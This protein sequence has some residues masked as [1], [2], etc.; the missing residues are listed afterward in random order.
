M[1]RRSFLILIR[2]N[3]SAE[4]LGYL[5]RCGLERRDQ[6]RN[7]IVANLRGCARHADGCDSAV[8][9]IVEWHADA[10]KTDLAFLVF[11]RV[12]QLAYFFQFARKPFGR[13]DRVLVVPCHGMSNK[14]LHRAPIG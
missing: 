14:S 3:V 9:R 2:V 7:S 5:T 8:G 1:L 13:G 4:M 10:A 11:K 12:A 6:F